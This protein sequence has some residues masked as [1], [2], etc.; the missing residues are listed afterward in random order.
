[1]NFEL[2]VKKLDRELLKISE[3]VTKL[4]DV[5]QDSS[6]LTQAFLNECKYSGIKR[7][8]IRKSHKSIPYSE[9]FPFGPSNSVFADEK[10]NDDYPIIWKVVN[11]FNISAGCGSNGQHQIKDSALLIDGT[12]HLKNGCWEKIN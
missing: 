5:L 4:R 1:M 3:Q 6:K 9:S 12:Y 11:K 8:C 10:D 7:V 2:E